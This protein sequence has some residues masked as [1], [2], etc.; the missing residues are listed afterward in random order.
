[1]VYLFCIFVDIFFINLVY[2]VYIYDGMGRIDS[3]NMY[4]DVIFKVKLEGFIYCL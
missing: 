4:Y 3:F 1:M 2:W